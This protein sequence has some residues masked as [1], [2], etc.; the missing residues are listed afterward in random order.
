MK[1]EFNSYLSK[2]IRIISFFSII[3][4]VFIHSY[5]NIINLNSVSKRIEW[6]FNLFFQNLFSNGITRIAVPIFFL[7]S[8]L[9]FFK[10]FNTNS[11]ITHKFFVKIK[12]RIRTLFIPYMFWSLLGVVI[13]Y[14]LQT[15]SVSKL[16]FTKELIVNYSLGQ[17]LNRIF[18]DPIPYQ[19]WFIRDLMLLVFISPILYFLLKKTFILYISIILMSFLWILEYDLVFISN[20]SLLF[21]TVGSILGIKNLNIDIRLSVKT[22]FIGAFTWI[23]LIVV[24]IALK[25]IEINTNVLVLLHKTSIIIGVLVIWFAYD[26]KSYKLKISE[27]IISFTFFIYVFH[28]PLLTILKKGFYFLFGISELSSFIIYIFAPFIAIGISILTGYFLKKKA[29]TFYKLITGNR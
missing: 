8:G 12:K 15:A 13:Y 16:F 4:V 2:K 14:C 25:G 18:I 26:I 21:F 5:N 7:L 9:L 28:E 22:I 23:L 1:L 17:L 24:K 20:E 11:E 6:E 19:L 29:N 3:M 27:G 10:D